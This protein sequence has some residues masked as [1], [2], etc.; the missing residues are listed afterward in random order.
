MSTPQEGAV[1]PPQLAANPPAEP[2]AITPQVVPPVAAPATVPPTADLAALQSQ[3]AEEKTARQ[4]AEQQ[5]LEHQR[6]FTQSRQQLSAVLGQQPQQDPLAPYLKTYSEAGFTGEDAKFLATRDFQTDQRFAA[7]SQSM[8]AQQQAPLIMQQV[9]QSAP[10]LFGNAQTVQA[11]QNALAD[12][13]MNGR[14]DLV[15]QEY[16]LNIGL[17]H[18]ARAQLVQTAGTP[19]V[20]QFPAPPQAQPWT[21]GFNGPQG[22]FN[23]PPPPNNAP[24]QL[25]PQQQAWSADLQSTFKKTP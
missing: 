10:A 16:A 14:P 11:M 19:P 8:Q 7:L 3:L 20:A 2:V 5:A 1:T 6:A 15:S 25:S 24:K 12:A 23:P 21:G 18:W 4:R 22:G 9:H 17:Q 13:A